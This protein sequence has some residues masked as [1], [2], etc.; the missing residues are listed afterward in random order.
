MALRHDFA[1]KKKTK[2]VPRSLNL[3][4]VEES[5]WENCDLKKQHS[6]LKQGKTGTTI[7]SASS[8]LRKSPIQ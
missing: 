7:A 2:W 4:I 8:T 1:D 5:I 3:F 6:A